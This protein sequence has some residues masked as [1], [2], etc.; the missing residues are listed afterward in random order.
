MVDV[1]PDEPTLIERLFVGVLG[2]I[3]DAAAA[4]AH[5]VAVLAHD[6]GL[7]RVFSEELFDVHHRGVHLALHVGGGGVFPVP[8]NALVVHKAAGVGAAKIL[9]HLPQRFPAV[10][11]VAAGPDQDGRVIFVQH[12][13]G[14]GKHI[15]PPLRAVAGQSPFVR[16]VG[17]QL[18]PGTMRFQIRFL[19]DIQAVLIAQREEIRIVGVMAGAH[20]VDVVRLEIFHIPE[21]FFPADSAAG[22]AAPLVAVDPFEHDALAVQQYL[23]VFQFKPAQTDFQSGALHQCFPIQ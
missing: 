16:A 9:A 2:V 3:R 13:F 21:H 19:D 6:K 11:L 10:A 23:A 14:T 20:S 22:L 7:F 1:L 15:F 4:V 5:G 12:G 17:P 8:E 18:L